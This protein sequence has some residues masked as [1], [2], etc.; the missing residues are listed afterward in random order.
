MKTLGSEEGYDKYA[1]SYRKD[2]PH[3]DSFDWD[4]A[5][6]WI[7]EAM[8]PL[9]AR[10]LDAGCGDGRVLKRLA[11]MYPDPVPAGHVLEGRD[12]SKGMLAQARKAVPAWVRLEH[13]D[14]AIPR[15]KG[16]EPFGLVLAFFVLVHL[17]NP[18]RALEALSSWMS[19]GGILIC[20]TFPQKEAPVLEAG[21]HRFQIAYRDH[22]P[23]EILEAAAS[24]GLDVLDDHEGPWSRLWR[25]RKA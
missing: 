22:D 12:I 5:R 24:A 20:N 11:K 17:D 13:R 14:V 10:V 18:D 9:P 25:F 21:G 23:G 2:H 4:I 3:L 6:P 7:K 16:G 15:E 8:T 19:P 1:P